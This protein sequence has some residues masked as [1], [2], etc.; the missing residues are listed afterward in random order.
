MVN[1]S[2]MKCAE[3]NKATHVRMQDR[4]KPIKLTLNDNTIKNYINLT[5]NDTYKR[6]VFLLIYKP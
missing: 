5:Q 2:I 1:L 6:L 4:F 3:K